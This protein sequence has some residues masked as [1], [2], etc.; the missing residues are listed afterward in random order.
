[1]RDESW[2]SQIPVWVQGLAKSDLHSRI[3]HENSKKFPSN[4]ILHT[5]PSLL[6]METLVPP[7]AFPSFTLPGLGL[8]LHPS[9]GM[10][11]NIGDNLD[12]W[13]LLSGATHLEKLSCSPLTEPA[14]EFLGRAPKS[15]WTWDPA[16]PVPRA[17][18]EGHCL[19]PL[20]SDH[21][22]N[23]GKVPAVRTSRI[24]EAVP[25]ERCQGRAGMERKRGGKNGRSSVYLLRPFIPFPS[26][27]QGGVRSQSWSKTIPSKTNLDPDLGWSI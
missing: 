7:P 8:F 1:M 22:E 21:L 16:V 17:A 10:I 6:R 2:P 25:T 12:N 14:L 18:P 20:T 27:F 19:L 23:P 15:C 5:S 3:F 11:G 9:G 4:P 26:L 24:Q 13:K